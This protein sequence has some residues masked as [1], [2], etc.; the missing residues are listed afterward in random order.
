MIIRQVD[1]TIL[2]KEPYQ[3][4]NAFVDLLAMEEYDNLSDIQRIAH[5]AFWYDTE[6]NNGGHLQYFEN[7]RT[8]HLTDTIN[9]LK[10][11]GAISQAEILREAGNQFLNKERKPIKSVFTFV[12]KAKEGEFDE[13]DNRYYECDPSIQDLL[14]EYLEK[15][16]DH[17][18]EVL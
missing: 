3:V 2:E 11:L 12:R 9:A 16:K 7:K 13:F 17:F 8:N 15:N 4:W 6:V 1:K 14:E 5:L 10:T 18:V